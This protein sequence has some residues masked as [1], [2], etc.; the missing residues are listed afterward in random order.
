MACH[1]KLDLID[2]MGGCRR[3]IERDLKLTALHGK[4]LHRAGHLPG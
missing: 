2:S 1:E 4:R 3:R